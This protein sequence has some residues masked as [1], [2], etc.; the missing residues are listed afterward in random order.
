M[1]LCG[2]IGNRSSDVR[3][4]RGGQEGLE[5]PHTF[6]TPEV[7]AVA[8]V[9]VNL[10]VDVRA[11]PAPVAPRIGSQIVVPRPMVRDRTVDASREAIP[12]RHGIAIRPNGTHHGV[13]AA[14]LAA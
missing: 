14:E 3:I 13:V 2:T 5:A 8:G 4:L 6:V 12:Q 11:D 7:V 10:A 1:P 9:Q